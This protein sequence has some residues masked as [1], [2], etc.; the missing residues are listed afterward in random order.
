MTSASTLLRSV[1]LYS[2]CLPMA[3]FLGYLLATPTDFTTYVTIGLVF[4]LLASP[5]FLRWHHIWLIASWNLGAVLFFLPG[6][7]PPW[8]AMAAVSLFI[9]VLQFILNRRLK[10]LHA[11][12][13]ARP[14]IFLGVVVVVTMKLSGGFG[15]GML[16]S[17]VQGGKRYILILGAILGYFALTSRAI[18]PNRSGLCVALFFLGS[19][20]NAVGELAPVLT[21]SLYFIFLLFPVST[22]GMTSI[23]SDPGAATSA[24]SRLGGV[25]VGSI[26]ISCSLLAR[27]GIQQLFTLRRAGYML[28]F[29]FF[30]V[31]TTLGGYRSIFMVILLTSGIVFYLEG[32]MRSRLL[33]IFLF[34]GVAAAAV[35]VPLADRLPLSTQRALSFLPIHVDPVA[36]RSAEDTTEWRIHLWKDVLPEVPK[37]LI[38]GKGYAFTAADLTMIH[39]S[40]GRGGDAIEGFELVGDYHNGPLS[41]VLPFGIF[42]VFGFLWFMV[43]SIRV[44][45]KNYKFGP[46]EY[47][48]YNRLLLAYFL[49]KTILFFFVFGSLFSDI[50]TFTGLI[51]LSVSLNGG[52][53]KPAVVPQPKLRFAAFKLQ[54]GA[55]RGMGAT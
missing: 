23:M 4:T 15:L 9:S 36:R 48:H 3:V 18:H 8:M 1:L 55:R 17:D 40:I 14:L 2:I 34:L 10:F 32:L 11:P 52:V 42:G 25:A 27:F 21:P 38:L 16:G 46:V 54:P 31:V 22:E 5:L 35:V 12:E 41:I 43:A 47:H 6:R 26:A 39:S 13:I 53:A 30:V 44:L 49:A 45:Y 20:A 37:Y 50:S 51:G 33:P 19:V 7:P 29:L 24:V 28:T